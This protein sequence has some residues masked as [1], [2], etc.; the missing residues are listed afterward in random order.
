MLRAPEPQRHKA[1]LSLLAAS[2]QRGLPRLMQ[3]AV[4]PCLGPRDLGAD[5]LVLPV[6][7]SLYAAA[8]GAAAAVACSVLS[9]M[10][11]SCKVLAA[12]LAY[13]QVRSALPQGA[14]AGRWW[15]LLQT[16]RVPII[17][18]S[19]PRGQQAPVPGSR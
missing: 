15:R 7:Q 3:Q 8:S 18:E 9:R 16:C 4:L 19:A 12:M 2:Q 5:T 17:R 13:L 6:L 10:C 14:A 1:V 11:P